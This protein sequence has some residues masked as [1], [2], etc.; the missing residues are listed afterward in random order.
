MISLLL[1][2]LLLNPPH[3]LTIDLEL[4]SRLLSIIF[5]LKRG[6]LVC[7]HANL[8]AAERMLDA[9]YSLRPKIKI[10]EPGSHAG[11]STIPQP[12]EVKDKVLLHVNAPCPPP[13]RV[14]L[15]H[16]LSSFVVR[17]NLDWN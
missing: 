1:I 15:N 8:M 11:E 10:I 9:A 3:S 16:C 5:N 4:P 6:R 14:A 13:T 12:I 17:M 7:S 2:P